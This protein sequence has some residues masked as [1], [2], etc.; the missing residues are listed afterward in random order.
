MIKPTSISPFQIFSR[1]RIL[2]QIMVLCLLGLGPARAEE[3]T[4]EF[5]GTA[6]YVGPNLQPFFQVGNLYIFSLSYVTASAS[7]G[8]FVEMRTYTG[9]SPAFTIFGTGGT[10]SSSFLLPPQVE[11]ANE[12]RGDRIQVTANFT[13]LGEAYS[14][15][16]VTGET[17]SDVTFRLFA[18]APGPLTALDLPSGLTLGDWSTNPS[19]TGFYTCWLP[20]LATDFMRFSMTEINTPSAIPEPSTYAAIA[21]LLALGGV[22]WHRH[23]QRF[24]ST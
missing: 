2:L 6:N 18:N 1:V 14:H 13:D 5:T 21:G 4:L 3:V 12:T 9:V 7:T 24:I 16:A 10:W 11:V 19:Q 17:L 15:T 23:N 22:I 20:G 8:G